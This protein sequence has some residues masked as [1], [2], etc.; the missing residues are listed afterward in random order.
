MPLGCGVL[1]CLM[2][3]VAI[4]GTGRIAGK[5]APQIEASGLCRVT[6][7]ASRDRGRAGAFAA[8]HGF[9]AA[10]LTYGEL[11]GTDACDAVYVTLPNV[12]HPGWSVR[13]A[14]AG[15][16]VLCEKPLAWR[17]ADAERVFAAGAVGAGG[18]RRVVQEAFMYLHSPV[19]GQVARHVRDAD[20]PIGRLERI[21][22]WFEIGIDEGTSGGDWK[23][24]RYSRSL[25]G[26]S[27]MDLG[28]YP[29]SL[30]RFVTGREPRFVSG[31]A[32][33]SDGGDD[34]VDVSAVLE[35]RFVGVELG[36]GGGAGGRRGSGGR[37]GGGGERRDVSF[38]FSSSMVA[39]EGERLAHA[40]FVGDRGVMD[41]PWFMFPSGYSVSGAAGGDGL[42]K[43][44][45]V[46]R[47][48][49]KG[50]YTRQADAFARACG[51]GGVG[52]ASETER[53]SDSRGTSEGFSIG[54]AAAMEAGLAAIG[55]ELPGA[56]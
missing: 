12:E 48:D 49:G 54:Q 19:I 13:L 31:E 27:L 5:V 43:P 34:S 39:G 23:N 28:C 32:V 37:G 42:G 14:R 30:G 1:A 20:G 8:G 6:A 24:V 9:D 29:I 47:P 17:R 45:Y 21:E 44:A 53:D 7:V 41:V 40:R 15:K 22:A 2:L 52:V 46:D 33:F 35:G 26:G 4:M 51:V 10:A 16:H 3:R 36:G 38:R 18:G 56:W 50:L 55:L 25:A 11:E